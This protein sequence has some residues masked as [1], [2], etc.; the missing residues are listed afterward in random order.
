MDA[1]LHKFGNKASKLLSR[2]CKGPN[3]PT[4]I[5]SLRDTS[6]NIK[7]TQKGINKAMLQY[8]SSLYMAD[9]IDTPTAFSF[10]EKVTLSQI[11]P[12]QLD[13]LNA[14]ISLPEISNAIKKT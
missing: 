13:A 14:P 4:Y 8:Y 1:T 10:L 3:R 11:S 2:L 7:T 5:T 9:P 6:G 12:S